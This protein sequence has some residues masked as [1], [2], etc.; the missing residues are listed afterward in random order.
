[1]PI[2]AGSQKTKVKV[3][4]PDEGSGKDYAEALQ[5]DLLEDFSLEKI[6]ANI[7]ARVIRG[8][9]ASGE[10]RDKVV[11]DLAEALFKA[12][13]SGFTILTIACNTLSLECF[14][15][16]AK[17]MLLQRLDQ[18]HDELPKYELILTIGEIGKY[19]KEAE[20]LDKKVLIL[21]T[22]PLS[23]I[24]ANGEGDEKKSA[25]PTL[26]NNNEIDGE[27]D[28]YLD[29]V[30]E[31]IWR[32]KAKQGSDTRSAPQYEKPL[33]DPGALDEKLFELFN[34]LSRLRPNAIVMGCTE[35]PEAFK[36]MKQ[37]GH[38]LGEDLSL[39]DPAHL[40]AKAINDFAR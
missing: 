38:D 13:E 9:I 15:G 1:M 23:K 25:L 24:L 19:V 36:M 2:E 28:H 17:E 22:K 40:V 10:D 11:F 33:N 31:I 34:L 35:L 4:A 18:A 27:E 21:G 20:A 26:A 39:V 29:L 32:I 16:P 6:L 7:S 8:E 5:K 3:I 12:I 30:Q 37:L 14:I